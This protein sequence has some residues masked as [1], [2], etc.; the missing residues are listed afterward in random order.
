MAS[1]ITLYKRLFLFPKLPRSCHTHC[2]IKRLLIRRCKNPDWAITSFG[3]ATLSPRRDKQ[4]YCN[5]VRSTTMQGRAE[6]QSKISS[7]DS[8]FCNSE[9]ESIS[10]EKLIP[11]FSVFRRIWLCEENIAFLFNIKLNIIRL[12]LQLPAWLG[13]K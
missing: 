10:L 1:Q 6:N 5:F 3:Q 2:A 13:T 7:S 11:I 4:F 12:Y 8:A 9:T